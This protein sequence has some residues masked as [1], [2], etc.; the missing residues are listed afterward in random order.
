MTLSRSDTVSCDT[1]NSDTAYCG[2]ILVTP[3]IVSLSTM[4]QTNV[5]Y[6]VHYNILNVTLLIVTLSVMTLSIAT[7]LPIMT[8]FVVPPTIESLSF[9]SQTNMQ[10]YIVNMTL[11]RSATVSCDTIQR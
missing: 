6:V 9:M 2:K 4:S 11:S 1:F 8:Q 3:P 10:L 7:L 5:T